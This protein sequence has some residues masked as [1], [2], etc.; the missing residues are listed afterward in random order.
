MERDLK[1]RLLSCI[2]EVAMSKH[3][4]SE[5]YYI[6]SKETKCEPGFKGVPVFPTVNAKVLTK[7]NKK[8]V[9][10]LKIMLAH[11]YIDKNKGK[12]V[13]IQEKQLQ[14]YNIN[15]PPRGWIIS[16]KYDGIRAIWD[17]SKFVSR[18]SASGNPKV[19]SYVP[20]WFQAVMPPNIALDGEIFMGRGK[21][22]KISGISNIE[23]GRSYSE[24]EIN[25]IWST[26]QYRIFDIMAIKNKS[27]LE[28]PL[29]ERLVLI[30]DVIESRCECWDKLTLPSYVTKSHC[31][32]VFT[33]HYVLKDEQDLYDK[34][35]EITE[36]GGEGVMIRHPNSP[37]E[38]KRSKFMLKM[39]LQE[40]DECKVTAY[41][42]GTGKYGGTV[43]DSEGV[44]HDIL[45]AL[46]CEMIKNG[47]LTGKLFQIGTGLK[48][49][50]RKNYW[51][52]DSPWYIPLGSIINYGYME[53][54]N[55]GIPRHPTFRGVR[56]DFPKPLTSSEAKEKKGGAEF[57]AQQ[58][59]RFKINPETGRPLIND[60]IINAFIQMI[61][62]VTT[63]RE[64][65]W[66]FKKRSYEKV[67]NLI[68][69]IQEPIKTVKA[70]DRLL[71]EQ[72]MKDP[73][74]SLAKIEEI[75][76]TGQLRA[77]VESSRDP[78]VQATKL[79]TQISGI[80]AVK[81]NELYTKY[82]IRTVAELLGL[83]ES[84]P[85]LFTKEQSATLRYIDDLYVDREKLVKRR[86]PRQ[87]IDKVN[88]Y[89]CKVVAKLSGD[90]VF[91]ITGSYRRKAQESGDI[92][93]LIK[94]CE[95]NEKVL[96]ELI[97]ILKASN[98]LLQDG[99]KGS[100]VKKY[101]GLAKIP[102]FPVVSMDILYSS[103][104]EY[105]FA[106]LYFTGSKSF[107]EIFRAYV[108]SLGYSINEFGITYNEGAKKDRP[109]S[110]ADI[111]RKLGKD[112]IDTEKDIFNF[113]GFDYIEPEDR[114]AEHFKMLL[115]RK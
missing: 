58:E 21:F 42:K 79:L 101:R 7:G 26:V 46:Q 99:E 44:K 60:E 8:Y 90:N 89:L 115:K 24:E 23:P 71:K 5:K 94:S 62:K 68:K 17:G 110:K 102:G 4:K 27:L 18:G 13:V 43:K 16:E 107:A 67:I 50:Q 113:F 59:A 64:Q 69:K 10:S 112:T 6:W 95:N 73:R 78:K 103:P 84:N 88:K 29:K 104:K 32:L 106:L 77:A 57:K 28:V 31:P 41:L 38:M 72:G 74:K 70:A 55:D 97:K 12:T 63:T 83:F 9:P 100:G 92:D 98:V 39:K 15:N 93:L 49:D 53:L 108:N 36:L 30:K 81:A 33:E 85:K 20:E 114:T 105:P 111:E 96:K 56:E 45:G 3:Y 66:V 82:N 22:Q 109:I 35:S 65:N 19:Y 14:K 61:D 34:Y 40:D 75:L 87:L 76:E 51:N 2:K 91:V 52:K 86:I 54:S 47:V 37:Y 80:G 48:D 1:N 11:H 25:K